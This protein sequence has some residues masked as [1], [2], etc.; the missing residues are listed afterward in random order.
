M[1]SNPITS[2]IGVIYLLCPLIEAFFPE[3]AGVCA[4]IQANL[5]GIGFLSTADGIRTR[6]STMFEAKDM[7]PKP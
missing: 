5:I 3:A 4:K 6:F 2:I 7:E 1:F